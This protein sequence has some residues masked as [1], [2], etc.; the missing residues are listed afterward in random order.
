MF[1]YDGAITTNIPASPSEEINVLRSLGLQNDFDSHMGEIMDDT[2]DH[3]KDLMKRIYQYESRFPQTPKLTNDQFK[4]LKDMGIRP[5]DIDMYLAE[6]P[7][8]H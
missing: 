8:F 4:R 7:E 6:H 5:E 1:D 3:Y 2:R